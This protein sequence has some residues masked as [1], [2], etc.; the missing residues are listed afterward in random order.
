MKILCTWN[1]DLD[2]L[3]RAIPNIDVPVLLIWGSRDA[4]VFPDSAP[5]LKS[6]LRN[7]EL[8][9]FSG[10]GHLPYEEVPDEFNHAVMKFLNSTPTG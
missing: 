6:H 5:T 9:M 10:V 2:E 7:C 3:Q 4:A 1:R 8:L